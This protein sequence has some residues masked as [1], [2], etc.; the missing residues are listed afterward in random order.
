MIRNL[1]EMGMSNRD[2]A[3]ELGISRNT[4]SRMLKKTRIQDRKRKRKGSKLDPYRDRI[5]ALIDEHNLSAVRILEEIR[6]LG[7]NGGYTILK[8]Y[9]RELRKNRR[10]QAVY[11]Y[12]TGPGKQ[13]QVDFGEFG[14]I[15]IDGKRKKLYAFSI[16][17]GYSRTRYAEFTA[18][19]STNNVIKMH[20]NSFTFFGGYTDT[21]LYDNM[22]Q[23][24]KRE[25]NSLN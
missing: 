24:A 2:I 22:N 14:S 8:E 6:K 17:L 5:H 9:C 15:E 23:R 20:L 10:I 12:E 1:K 18:D 4:V 19:I 21:M 7:Y 25:E 13:S 3:R 11:R 16:L